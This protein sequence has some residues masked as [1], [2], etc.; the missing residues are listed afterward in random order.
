MDHTCLWRDYTTK[1][2]KKKDARS[3]QDGGFDSIKER[4]R[5]VADEGFDEI[6]VLPP[7]S[8]RQADVHRTSAV[9]SVRIPSLP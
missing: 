6:M 4:L 9:K 7:S 8:W 5:R 1:A 2:R 3:N